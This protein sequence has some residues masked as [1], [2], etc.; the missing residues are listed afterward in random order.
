M[1]ETKPYKRRSIRLP[2]YDYSTSGAYF[3]TICSHKGQ[4]IFGNVVDG[5]TDLSP[6]GKLVENFWLAIP[7]HFPQAYLDDYVIM[8]NHIHGIIVLEESSYAGAESFGR[9]TKGSLATVLRSFKAAVTKEIKGQMRTNDVWQRGYY[10]HVIR[11]DRAMLEIKEYILTNAL[12]WE[13]DDMHP[14]KIN[15]RVRM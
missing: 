7:E 2:D 6:L 15:E 12:K 13:L 3:V 1:D 11:N 8:P 5:A 9:P 4:C 14:T 10:E